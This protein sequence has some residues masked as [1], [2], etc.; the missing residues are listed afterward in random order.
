MVV[1]TE[2]PGG[3]GMERIKTIGNPLKMEK[4][5]VN[6]FAR[7]PMLGEHTREVLMNLLGYSKEKIE[8]LKEKGVIKLAE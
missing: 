5:P 7:P 1:E 2:G 8:G 4:T 3:P 6:V